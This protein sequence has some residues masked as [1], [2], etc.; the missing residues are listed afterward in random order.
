MAFYVAGVGWGESVKKGNMMG[1]LLGCMVGKWPK[2]FWAAPQ[3]LKPMVP[4]SS[5][6]PSIRT[7]CVD[8]NELFTITSQLILQS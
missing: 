2:A 8:G 3:D 5:A 4:P 6:A 7:Q 1:S